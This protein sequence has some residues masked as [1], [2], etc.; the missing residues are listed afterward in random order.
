MKIRRLRVEWFRGIKELDWIVGA[1]F[2][3]LIGAGDSTKSTILSAIDLALSSR[4][5]IDIDDSDFHN[6]DTDKT[7]SI[8]VIVGG[9]P[10]ELLT[11]QK[12]GLCICGWSPA[13]DLHD[14]PE[15][16]DEKVFSVRLTCDSSLEPRWVLVSERTPEGISLSAK[17]RDRLGA[18]KIESYMDR[19]LS[20]SRGSVLSRFSGADDG[21]VAALVTASR[22]ARDAIKDGSLPELE[23]ISSRVAELARP[24]GVAPKTTFHPRLDSHFIEFGSS[25]LSLHD[26]DVP[27]RLAGLGTRRLVA[28]ALQCNNAARDGITLI[29]EVEQALEPHRLRRLLRVLRTVPK[30]DKQ[31]PP[32]T[33]SCG[34]VFCTTHSATAVQELSAAELAIVRTIDGI[35][36]VTPIPSNLQTTIRSVPE[37]LLGRRVLVCEGLTELGFCA[38]LDDWWAGRERRDSF[39]LLGV[40]RVHG[41]GAASAV[42]ARDLASLGYR[43]ALL[44]DSDTPF[45]PGAPEL[46]ALGI[47]VILWQG[48][49]AI[50]KRAAL[51]LPW[52]AV[53]E[54]V[55][56]AADDKGE[57]AVRAG[58]GSK[59]GAAVP[60]HLAAIENWTDSRELRGAIAA[61]TKSGKWLKNRDAGYRLGEITARNLAA[62][63]ESDL[64]RKL[65][66]L[67][68]WT[69]GDG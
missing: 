28:L 33:E 31:S 32:D 50:E 56:Y 27:L 53:L 17:D 52:S 51:D 63:P 24:L 42:R 55:R 69:D 29:D 62:I 16:D 68:A 18:F 9:L 54:V 46:Q 12:Y 23:K 7:L 39:S 37:C 35:T 2:V 44:G 45:H 8:T 6:G 11:D 5:K 3:C 36:T 1:N 60:S 19:H 61:A 4:W 13:G 15:E 38:A 49:V 22:A 25:G 48:G 21:T 58:I 26:G 14:E 40:V 34:Q 20:W 57:G 59:A 10:N 67:R 66:S 64:A 47:E 41:D 30:K 43:V 65:E